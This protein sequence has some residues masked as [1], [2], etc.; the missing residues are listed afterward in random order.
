MK[1]ICKFLLMLVIAGQANAQTGKQ[2]LDEVA[3]FKDESIMEVKVI[4]NLRQLMAKKM[5]EGRKFP[6]AFIAKMDNGT[7]VQGPVTLEVRG[8]FRRKNCDLPPLKVDFKSNTP[9]MF[10]SLGSLKLVNVC[11]P[12]VNKHSEFL[13]KEYL[14]YKLYNL[15][16]DKSFRVRLLKISYE[17]SAGKKRFNE[18][19]FLMEDLKD[20]AKRNDCVERKRPV[21]HTENTNRKQMTKVALFEYM[22]GNLDWSVPAGHNIKLIVGKADTNDLAFAVPYDFDHAGFVHTDYALPPPHVDVI[23][24]TERNYRGF[25]RQIEELQDE[26]SVFLAQKNNIYKLVNEFTLLPPSTRKEITR[27]LDEFFVMLT[28]PGQMKAEFIKNAR[29]E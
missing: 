7:E 2:T 5:D 26:A 12:T 27:F 17:D 21:K 3:F 15:L 19:A 20:M 10:S 4:L 23:S 11:R 13:L 25:S 16:T 14:I 6:A 8:K 9:F 1:S 22:I 28:K 18:Y 29:I 24:V